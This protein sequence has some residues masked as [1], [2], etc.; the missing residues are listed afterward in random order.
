MRVFELLSTMS[1]QTLILTLNRRKEEYTHARTRLTP[2]RVGLIGISV[3]NV[4]RYA[5]GGQPIQCIQPTAL[6]S[7]CTSFISSRR[8][9]ID[10]KA[11][12]SGRSSI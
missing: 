7:I 1:T 11:G 5:E 4:D 12:F 8:R 10:S 2:A 9:M 6:P 3:V